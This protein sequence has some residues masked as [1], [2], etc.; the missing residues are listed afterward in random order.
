MNTP[1]AR[2]TIDD[3][4]SQVVAD[5]HAGILLID[6][7]FDDACERLRNSIDSIHRESPKRADRS[8]RKQSQES[9]LLEQGAKIEQDIARIDCETAKLDQGLAA[10]NTSLHSLTQHKAILE[11]QIRDRW[12]IERL[13]Y[14]LWEDKDQQLC[15]AL[16]SDLDSGV[17]QK[18]ALEETK[19]RLDSTRSQMVTNRNNLQASL[20]QIRRT[21]SDMRTSV[22]HADEQ[23]KILAQRASDAE[24]RRK[25]RKDNLLGSLSAAWQKAAKEIADELRLIRRRQPAF[26]DLGGVDSDIASEMP[27]FLLLGSQEVAFK[28][29]KC[30]IPH[31]IGFPFERALVLPEDNQAQRRLAHHLL[32]RLLQAAPPGRLEL[33]LIDPLRLGQSFSPFL[34]LLSVEKLMPECRVLTRGDEIE[35]VLG[36]LMDETEYLIQQ[37]FKGRVSNWSAFNAENPDA[38]LSYKVVLLFDV[39]EQLSEKSLWYIERLTESGPRCGILPII[40]VDGH[41]IEDKRFERLRRTL[42]LSTQR[43]DRCLRVEAD[44]SGSLSHTYLPEFWPRQEVLDDFLSKL[45]GHYADI[46]RFRRSLSELWTGS[47][48]SIPS[49]GGLDVPIGWTSSGKTVS[50]TLG[51]STSEHHALLAGKTG[52]GKSNLLHVIIHSLCEKYSPDELDLYLLDYKE[53]TEFAVYANPLL[54]QARLVATESD[55]EYGVTVLEHL[56]EELGRR[57][58]LFKS[59]GL[60]DFSEYRR[61]HEVPL[62]RVLLIIDEFQVLFTEGRQVA[63]AAEKLIAQLLKQGRSFGI[64]LLL[65]TQTLKGI[66]ALSLGALMSQLGCRIALACGQEDSALILGGNNMAAADLK[67]PPEAIINT[68]NGATSGNVRFMVPLAERSICLAHLQDLAERAFNRG[69]HRKGRVFDGAHLPKSPPLGEYGKVCGQ[70][71][72]IL[73]GERLTFAADALSAPLFARHGFNFLFSGFNDA[74]HDGLLGSVL[75][76]IAAADAFD[77][78]VYFDGRGNGLRERFCD[79]SVALRDRLV[80]VA[81]IGQ[82]PLEK[83]ASSIGERRV[84]LIID[85]LD[86]EKTLHPVQT[87]KAARQGDAVPP[88]DLLKKIAEEGP[89]QGTVVFAFIENWRRCAVGCKELFSLF[90]V[91]VAFCMNEDDAGGLVSGGIG[92]FKG[93]ERPNRSV[94][95][96]RMTNEIHW[97]RPYADIREGASC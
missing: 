81:D 94:F 29:L 80:T 14:V 43:L 76:S 51:A 92:K 68:S 10:I 9:K 11:Q 37:R 97:F 65:A 74:V 57:A 86:A 88:A 58:K 70:G 95:V 75:A 5:Y 77:D 2:R 56:V 64:H 33:T 87:F 52:S 67:S 38:P 53:S 93:I 32:L 84:A 25:T 79:V 63:D 82:L 59:A 78:I 30:V 45:S 47:A 55:P 42:I 46:G 66:N 21:L 96:N 40:A 71:D 20:D 49:V 35:E 91:R 36:R 62:P 6:R 1:Q 54:P 7:E 72:R 44:D 83:I 12:L 19:R 4:L 50:L 31:A 15:D 16:Q 3:P 22:H 34:P 90:E 8:D 17:R 60:R 18:S 27:Q 69:V 28:Q 61:K 13:I 85:G 26:S 39:P 41:R 23:A 73:L 24:K 89:Q 48:P